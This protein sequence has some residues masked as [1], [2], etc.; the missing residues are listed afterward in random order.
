MIHF[1]KFCFPYKPT[2]VD[3]CLKICMRKSDLE[4]FRY[5]L[6]NVKELRNGS[7]TLPTLPCIIETV[8][9]PNIPQFV[10]VVLNLGG[11]IN[12][13]DCRDQTA[14]HAAIRRGCCVEYLL[15]KGARADVG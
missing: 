6:E 10:E 4:M 11:D 12:F 7:P 3:S 8:D 9:P 13:L 1:S 14:L 2:G 15:Q 5:L